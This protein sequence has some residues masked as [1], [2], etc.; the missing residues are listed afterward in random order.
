M[1]TYAEL[2]KIAG[3]YQVIILCGISG[4]GKTMLSHQLEC[5]GFTRI[6]VDEIIWD[7]YA[8]QL[9]EMDK[10]L[11]PMIFSSG[12][13]EMCD[14]AYNLLSK[15]KR[16]VIDS[17]MCKR[18]KRDKI[19]EIC[20]KHGATHHLIYLEASY[21]ILHQRLN[22]R[23]G[24]NANDQI[25]SDEDLRRYCSNFETPAADEFPLTILTQKP[26]L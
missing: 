16:I 9:S 21:D 22:S 26:T 5:I 14:N 24:S 13:D 7:K 19:R 15:G 20:R 10:D 18:T 6:S 25:V 4:S 1:N 23:Q 17:T 11:L 3:D 2:K 8:N 12:F